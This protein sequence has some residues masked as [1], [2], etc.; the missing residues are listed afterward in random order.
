MLPIWLQVVIALVLYVQFAYMFY[1]NEELCPAEERVTDLTTFRIFA[2]A[3]PV[4]TIGIWIAAFVRIL[5]FLLTPLLK[6][7]VRRL[8][9][10]LPEV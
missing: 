4:L 5:A 7:I 10:Y 9:H 1:R 8:D 6:S 2:A 3:W